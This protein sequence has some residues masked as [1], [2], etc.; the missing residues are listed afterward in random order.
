MVGPDSAS[1]RAARRCLTGEEASRLRPTSAGHGKISQPSYR[2]RELQNQEGGARPSTAPTDRRKALPPSAELEKS[3]FAGRVAHA[4]EAPHWSQ[5][6]SRFASRPGT[7]PIRQ[8]QDLLSTGSTVATSPRAPQRPSPRQDSA[9]SEMFIVPGLGSDAEEDELMRT[10]LPEDLQAFT[11]GDGGREG[12]KAAQQP[13]QSLA[14]Q[15]DSSAGLHLVRYEAKRTARDPVSESLDRKLQASFG[16]EVE[17][18]QLWSF[19]GQQEAR[20]HDVPVQAPRSQGSFDLEGHPD[21]E[22]LRQGNWIP[23]AFL[24]LRKEVLE[25]G[26]PHALTRL[27]RMA[28]WESHKAIDRQSYWV[29]GRT[30]ATQRQFPDDCVDLTPLLH[31]RKTRWYGE[32]RLAEPLDKSGPPDIK[33]ETP[34]A[35]VTAQSPLDCAM[36]LAQDEAHHPLV[37]V[38]EVYDFDAAGDIDVHNFCS[39][40]PD[41]LLIRTDLGYFLEKIKREVRTSSQDRAY[42]YNRAKDHMTNPEQPYIILC[43]DVLAFRGTAEQGYPFLKEPVRFN[44]VL[45]A[46]ARNNPALAKV[47]FKT[48][49]P[50]DWYDS[51]IDFNAV[52]A[53]LKLLAYMLRTDMTKEA[54]TKPLLVMAIPGFSTN[55]QH[56]F[57]AVANILKHFKH[58]YGDLLKGFFLCS[59]NRRGENREMTARIREYMDI[60]DE[61]PPGEDRRRASANKK[62]RR[63][64]LGCVIWDDPSDDEG[65]EAPDKAVAQLRQDSARPIPIDLRGLTSEALEVRGVSLD[66]WTEEEVGKYMRTQ[67]N[68]HRAIEEAQLEDGTVAERTIGIGPLSQG[69]TEAELKAHKAKEVTIAGY[70]HAPPH[71]F[72]QAREEKVRKEMGTSRRPPPWIRLDGSNKRSPESADKYQDTPVT[73]KSEP[74]GSRRMSAPVFDF[75]PGE[76]EDSFGEVPQLQRRAS[77]VMAKERPG[78][79]LQMEAKVAEMKAFAMQNMKRK[80][81]QKMSQKK[82]D[83]EKVQGILRRR[84]SLKGVDGL[85]FGEDCSMALGSGPA[86]PPASP[87]HDRKAEDLELRAAARKR[88]MAPGLS[89]EQSPPPRSSRSPR[90]H[91]TWKSTEQ[92]Q[93]E[94]HRSA[95]GPI[96]LRAKEEADEKAQEVHMPPKAP[97]VANRETQFKRRVFRNA[98]KI[99]GAR[100]GQ[101]LNAG[102][103]RELEVAQAENESAIVELAAQVEHHMDNYWRKDRNKRGASKQPWLMKKP[104]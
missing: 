36:K 75:G 57:H 40:S 94:L 76:L 100:V 39:I 43:K 73:S 51:P 97:I 77:F 86:S 21:L 58:N 14:L 52:V 56:A 37:M 41:D 53:R 26:D 18:Q 91:Q 4:G 42:D 46:H 22:Y 90:S 47:R 27:H 45:M 59:R 98:A 31:Y 1:T 67:I 28:M 5:G 12:P 30:D 7:A 65:P 78:W 102:R 32:V 101:N 60:P 23:E 6:S 38:A 99:Y 11:D 49:R 20:E 72:L 10:G 80:V 34:H 93:A 62:R 85:G 104:V 87:G 82:E 79:E 55:V 64:I 2:V 13:Q 66:C 29:V 95:K 92:D 96:V 35:V 19:G 70:F 17:A 68:I 48:R 15:S 69:L 74:I 63:M 24:R 103:I 33:E 61:L 9:A 84:S 88:L 71:C 54:G 50:A 89:G 25:K 44:V 81:Q 16:Q 8:K 83:L 3:N